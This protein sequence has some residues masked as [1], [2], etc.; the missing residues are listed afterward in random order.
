MIVGKNEIHCM[1][2]NPNMMNHSILSGWHKEYQEAKKSIEEAAEL[3]LLDESEAFLS[4]QLYCF[5]PNAE[6][7]NKHIFMSIEK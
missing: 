3:Y 1:D 5:N 7:F 6:Y 2:S 4:H